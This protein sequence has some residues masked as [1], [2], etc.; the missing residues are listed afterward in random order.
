MYKG[1]LRLQH[2]TVVNI[3]LHILKKKWKKI[4]L[5]YNSA[6]PN[7]TRLVCSPATIGASERERLQNPNKLE[8]RFKKGFDAAQAARNV[9]SNQCIEV[10]WLTKSRIQWPDCTNYSIQFLQMNPAVTL[11]LIKSSQQSSDFWDRPAGSIAQS[12][13]HETN[14]SSQVNL[15]LGSEI[16]HKSLRI[17]VSCKLA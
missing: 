12:I 4:L 15:T 16:H 10:K 3:T 2:V 14:S 8:G 13:L 11:N 1:M 7:K 5:A 17:N 9:N 6:T